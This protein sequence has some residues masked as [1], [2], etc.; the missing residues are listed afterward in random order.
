MP[1]K[2]EDVDWRIYRII[3][4][5]NGMTE[6]SIICKAGLPEPEVR[7][8]IARLRSYFLV[9]FR[10]GIYDILSIP[11]M[12]FRN[13]VKHGKEMPFVVENGVIRV[14]DKDGNG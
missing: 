10:D 13:Q 3:S 8:S 7:A 12:F 9:D 11:E 5:G 4:S 2:D 6:E 14:K 1:V